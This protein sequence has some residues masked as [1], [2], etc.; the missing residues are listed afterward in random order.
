MSDRRFSSRA[1]LLTNPPV[2]D[3]HYSADKIR[4]TFISNRKAFIPL[5]E[6]GYRR[7]QSKL[8]PLSCIFHPIY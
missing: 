8:Y 4:E 2:N 7:E 5:D 3:E 1:A 6:D